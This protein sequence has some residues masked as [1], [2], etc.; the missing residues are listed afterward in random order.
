MKVLLV[1]PPVYDFSCFDHWLKPLGLLYIS[2]ILK[3]N[4]F[5]VYLLD[6]MDRFHS[7]L[8]SPVKDKKYGQGKFFNKVIEKK[9]EVLK[10]IPK[11][12]RRYGLPEEN[13]IKFL[14]DIPKPDF[15]ILTSVMTYWY[16]GVVEA[17]NTLKKLFPEVPVLLGGNYATLMP[18]H[19]FKKIKPDYI[20]KGISLVELERFFEENTGENISFPELKDFP[21]PDFSH[22]RKIKY[23]TLR[24]SFGCPYHCTYCGIKKFYSDFVFKNPLK[25]V[26]EIINL[27]LKYN[28]F[29]FVFYDDALI[30][31]NGKNLK[32]I[33]KNLIS[34]DYK[35]RFHTPNGLHA[36]F[37]DQELAEIF[38]E[39]KFIEPRLSLETANENRLKKSGGKLSLKNFEKAVENLYNAGYKEKEIGSYIMLGMP[40]QGLDEVKDT[41]MYA[42]NLGLKV[43][44]A[45]YAVVPG[46]KDAQFFDKKVLE[47]PL[48][49]NNSIYPGF[50]LDMWKEI[51]EIKRFARV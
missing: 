10:N 31:D 4:N 38:F 18:E 23:I 50:D 25:V 51:E 32:V 44:L 9:P 39:A 35:F 13:A 24:T 5:D 26:D 7:C 6:Y 11:R 28:V 22:Y 45:E 15:I 8:G 14:K 48:L 36:N 40:G 41:V 43:R 34:R 29:D 46:T 19:A 37:I 17:R 33:L 1:N 12:W 30:A 2:K 20:F 42:K 47:E 49:H 27:H 3:N 21:E 16:Y